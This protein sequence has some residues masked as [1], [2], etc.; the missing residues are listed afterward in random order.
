MP[1]TTEETA[2][3][4][5]RIW[6]YA[7]LTARRHR[8]GHRPA[9]LQFLEMLVL[10]GRS[11]LGPAY[12]H[13]AGFWRKSVPFKTKLRHMG[14]RE[15]R[16]TT[17][18]LN[19]PGLRAPVRNKAY[20][21]EA[22]I[23]AGIPH[24]ALIG[25]VPPPDGN[26]SRGSRPPE[27]N[28]LSELA[29]RN[30]GRRLCIK[31]IDGGKGR[32]IFVV[33]VVSSE[34]TIF[35]NLFNEPRWIPVDDFY[36]ELVHLYGHHAVLVEEYVEQHPRLAALNP[37]SVNTLRIWVIRRADGTPEARLAALKIGR[38]GM[39]VDNQLQGGILAPV[40]LDSGTL[41][42]AIDGKPTR[43]TFAVHPDHGAP[44]EGQE[45]PLIREALRLAEKSLLA[46]PV[47]QFAGPDIAMGAHHPLV[48]E[49]NVTP[50][51]KAAIAT[52]TPARDVLDPGGDK[53]Q[54]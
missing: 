48:I 27:T 16:S 24:P 47:L 17:D 50:G 21:K 42:A 19:P 23:A 15:F 6:G 41:G 25:I 46:F 30:I 1:G 11:G 26:A 45:V 12:Y 36:R 37:T 39:S 13:A 51:I 14:D 53:W 8:E 52:D 35:F 54:L 5:R 9:L 10:L 38:E 29:A 33:E 3:L 34:G 40:N 7:G 49:T 2:S 31:P 28:G 43:E 18:R 44:I 4:P 32:G 20:Q 22:F